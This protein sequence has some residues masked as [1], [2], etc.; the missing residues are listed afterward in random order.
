MA[1]CDVSVPYFLSFLSL[2]SAALVWVSRLSNPTGITSRI[3][4][5]L[6][7]SLLRMGQGQA[8]FWA[9]GLVK[10]V[11]YLGIV[12]VLP[13]NLFRREASNNNKNRARYWQTKPRSLEFWSVVL[14]WLIGGSSSGENQILKS[15]WIPWYCHGDLNW[16]CWESGP[17]STSG[18]V[19]K[20]PALWLRPLY[21]FC[22]GLIPSI[23]RQL[24]ARSLTSLGLV[25]SSIKWGWY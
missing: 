13:L 1:G 14:S 12:F 23:T 7:G 21:P 18:P 5:L 11:E 6:L 24:R 2:A 15:V 3:T 4:R 10:Q 17:G 20:Q 22:L 9:C 19:V 25:F 16:R 8:S